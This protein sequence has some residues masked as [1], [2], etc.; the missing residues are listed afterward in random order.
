MSQ[1]CTDRDILAIE[2]NAFLAGG[3][4]S[5][6][7]AAGSDGAVTGTTFTSAASDFQPAAVEAG[8]VLCTY[9]TTPAEGT[10]C[11]I[12]SVDSATSLTVSVL[13][14]DS[15]APAV[16]PPE[17]SELS[18]RV[19]TFAPQIKSVSDTLARKLRQLAEVGGL[20]AADFADSAQLARV[21]A[22]GVLAA[23]FVA[24]AENAT[25]ADANWIKAEHY[26]NEFRRLQLQ[27]RLSVD[28]DGDGRAEQTRALGNV[29]LRRV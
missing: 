7:L 24:R 21:C 9:T 17:G 19:R 14:A 16:P 4:P 13:R 11:E 28:A 25:P 26:R 18:F 5:Q 2:P 3:F 20:A 10:A 29:A 23:V 12:V 1:F 27:L 15:E 8:M 22:Y 6:E